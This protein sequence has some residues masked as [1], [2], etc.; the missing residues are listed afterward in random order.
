LRWDDLNGLLRLRRRHLILPDTANVTHRDK[1]PYTVYVRANA[2][3]G[4]LRFRTIDSEWSCSEIGS[5]FK[6]KH[7]WI[8]TVFK[9]LHLAASFSDS[10][11]DPTT[12]P[13]DN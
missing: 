2:R 7:D 4:E 12:L 9:S 8:G 10:C 6:Q 13:I 3:V 5:R 11:A 1:V